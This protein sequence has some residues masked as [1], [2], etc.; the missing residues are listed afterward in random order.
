MLTSIQATPRDVLQL[1]VS[2]EAG[3]DTVS[4]LAGYEGPV[5]CVVTDH[6]AS[7]DAKARPCQSVVRL[8]G[9]S[10]WPMLDAPDQ[11]TRVIDSALPGPR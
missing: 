1:M 5:R 3:F 10:H 8:H 2:G 6:T 11:V 4:A 7:R 9:V